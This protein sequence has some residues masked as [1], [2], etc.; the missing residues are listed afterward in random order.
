MTVVQCSDGLSQ[1]R[2]LSSIIIG[3]GGSWSPVFETCN[4]V[5]NV[6]LMIIDSYSK[7]DEIVLESV[8]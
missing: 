6:S 8:Y 7:K 2:C 4:A 3:D 1:R 5:F